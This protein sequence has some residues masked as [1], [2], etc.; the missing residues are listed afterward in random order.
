MKILVTGGTVFVSKYLT[1]YFL[2]KNH[3]VYVFNR[4]THPQVNGAKLIQG[5]KTALCPALQKQDFDLILA[6][7]IYN[8]TEMKNLLDSLSEPSKKKD[9]IFISSSA[10]YPET[11]PLPFKESDLTGPNKIWGDYGMNKA[12]AENYLLKN[13]PQTYIL[14]PPYLYGK[15]QNLYREGFVF[16]CALKKMPFYLPGDGHMKLHFYHVKDLCLLIESLL[17]KRPER[18]IFNVGNTQPDDINN[19]IKICYQIVG[20]KLETICVDHTH[21]QRSYFPF[22]DYTYYLDVTEQNHIHIPEINLYDGLKEDFDY[23][24]RHQNEVFKK[25]SYFEYIQKN[26]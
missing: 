17:R 1:E 14:R 15:Y 23:Y 2:Q 7:N 10:V 13:I 8:Q 20:T 22:H 11:T 6:V 21:P 25:K 16:D 24:I 18:N 26:L 19:F 4:G 12:E 5:D 9:F 3:E